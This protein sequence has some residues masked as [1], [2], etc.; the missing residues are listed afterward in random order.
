[1]KWAFGV[2]E[3]K[4]VLIEKGAGA[5]RIDASVNIDNASLINQTIGKLNLVQN[6]D[7]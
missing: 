1:M 7:Q 6:I 4:T 2:Y 3:N 5:T